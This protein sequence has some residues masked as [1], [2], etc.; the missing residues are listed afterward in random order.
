IAPGARLVVTWTVVNRGQA[1]AGRSAAAVLL[2]RDAKADARDVRLASVSS[3]SL[4][5]RK[6]A[7]ARRE[8]V[9]P[10]STTPGRY[11]VLV[12]ADTRRSVRESRETN[13]CRAAGT[14]EVER[15][16]TGVVVT[17]VPTQ[18]TPPGA[19]QSGAPPPG[20]P[21]PDPPPAV[22]SDTTPP[23]T[24]ITQAPGATTSSAAA[25]LVFQATEAGSSFQ[26]RLDDEAFAPCTSPKDYSGLLAGEHAFEVRATDAAGNRD[27]SPARAAW[28]IQFEAPAPG[29]TDQP[30]DAPETQAT[31]SPISDVSVL[32]DSTAFLYE[33]ADPI[34]KD[35]DDGAI[36]AERASVLR[37]RVTRRNGSPIGGVRVTALDHP[38]LGR[39]ATR[40]DGGFE[41]AVNG[42]GSIVVQ[43]EHE[44]YV[45]SQRTLEVPAQD[46]ERVDSIVLV[47]YDDQ[48]SGVDL[49]S[50][51]GELQVAESAPV[52]DGDG[53]RQATLLLEPGTDATATL[54]DGSTQSLP[55]VL[56]IRATE[57]TIGE[58]GP[59][60]MPGE[61]PPSSAYTYAVE[62]SVDE[63]SE[64]GAVSVEFDKPVVTYVDNYLE[65]PAG[66]IVPMGYYDREKGQWIA[67]PNGRVIAIVGKANGRAQLDV[68][69][70]GAADPPAEV[71]ALGID[72]AELAKLAELYPIGRSLW[73]AAISHFTPWDYNWPYGLPDGARP[74]GQPGPDDGDPDDDDRCGASGSI[75]LCES[76]TL[77]ESVRV[78][79]TPYELTY[80]SERQPGRRT[81][82]AL[83]IP[84]TG[85]TVPAN[86]ARVD[87]D[88]EVAGRTIS[89]SFPP[90]ANQAE[91]FIFDGKDAYQRTVQGRQRV[92]VR[93]DYVYPAVYREPGAFV[94]SFAAIGNAALSGNP[95]RTE[96]SVGQRWS[97]YVG[98]LSAP[99]GA[100]GGWGLDVHHSYDPIGRTLYLGDGTRRSA[101]GQNFDVISTLS[102][103]L[104]FP[105]GLAATEEGHLLV[106]DSSAHVIRRIAEDGTTTVVAGT[107]AAGYGGDG[108]PATAAVLNH[109]S[110]VAVTRD[111]S[112]LVA[113]E[114][115]N[116]V[117][118]IG[119]GGTISTVAGT[120]EGGYAGDGGPALGAALDE[121]SDVATA[122]DGA[123]Y[124]VDRANHAVRRIGPDG[125]I[126]TVAGNGTP[127]S[128]GD[129]GLGADARLR[130]PRD[131]TV[132]D[133][134][135]FV[136]DGGNHRVRRI[137]PGGT[138]HTVA[139]NGQDG[140]SGD[141]GRATDATLDTPSAIVALP[142]GG[143]LV[144]DA[145]SAVVRKVAPEGTIAT[146]AG[147]GTPG[148]RGDGSPAASARIDFPQALVLAPDG[149]VYLADAG[150]D[151]VRKLAP[152][153]P[154]LQ[155]GEFTLPDEDGQHLFVFSRSGRHLRTVDTLTGADVLRFLYDAQG[156]LGSV[157]D[158]D[159][160]ETT[161]N[162][163]PSQA[164]ASIVGPYGHTTSLQSS[165]AGLLG[166]IENPAGER[167]LMEYD[168]GGLLTKLT[169]E[170]DGVHTFEYDALGRLTKDVAPGNAVQTLSRSVQGGAVT[171]T[172]TSAEGRVTTYKMERTAEGAI[173]RTVTDPSGG[174][175]T[176]ERR[177]DGTTTATKPT[178]QVITRQVGPDPRFGMQA[179]VPE[180]TTVRTPA[181]RTRTSE[182]Q[183][184][185][186]LSDLADPLS[187]VKVVE[188]DTVNGRASTSTFEKD[189]HKLTTR[190]P[191]GAP[192]TMTFDEQRRPLTLKLSGIEP[193]E[194]SYDDDGRLTERR[195]ASRTWS[196]TYGSQ[197]LVTGQQ[198]PLGRT[199]TFTYDPVGRET[200]R[201][202]P[203]T[204][205]VQT[206]YS[207]MG[208]VTSLTPPG[209][210]AHTFSYDARRDVSS[211]APPTVGAAGAATFSYDRDHALLS[212][213]RADGSVLGLE[214]DAGGR[215]STVVDPDRSVTIGYA[216]VTHRP[217]S[218][219][220]P[221]E[222]VTYAYDA[223]LP[224]S[225]T[226]DGA[227]DGV[228]D[229]SYD[230]EFRLAEAS[231]NGGGAIGLGYDVDGHL[232]QVGAMSLSH[233]PDNKLLTGTAL[234][235]VTTTRDHNGFG[236]LV[237]ETYNA[238]SQIYAADLA[239]DAGGRLVSEMTSTEAGASTRTYAYDGAGR[240]ASATTDGQAVSYSYDANGN[241]LSTTGPAGTTTAD[242]D[243]QD[244]LTRW[245]AQ[246]YAYT[247]SGELRTATDGVTGD[248]TTYEWDR[249]GTLMRVDLPGVA[250]RE[251]TVDGQG[252]RVAVSDNGSIVAR[253]VYGEAAGPSA[254]LNADGTVRTRYAY[255]LRGHVPELMVRGGET[256][257]FVLD[258]RGSVRLVVNT[259][260]GEVA[261]AMTYD[262]FGNVLTDSN[263]GFQPFGF[264]GGLYDRE[265]K[266]VHFGARD[267]DPATGRW[268]SKDPILFSGGDT[269]LYAYVFQDPVNLVDPSGLIFD[270][271]LDVAFIAYDL[272][273]IGESL[274]NGCGVSSTDAAAL[275]ADILGA[276]IPFGTGGGAA[277]R[278]ASKA[279]G[280]VNV[281]S[282]QR[283]THILHGDK[284]GGGHLW[285]GRSGKTPFPQSWSADRVMHEVSD[286]A[287]DPASRVVSTNGSRTVVEGTRDGVVI[288]VVTD[289]R[290]IITGHP[291]NLPRNP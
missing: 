223:S 247:A 3:R 7:K 72:D 200:S 12:C 92:D 275:G 266:L 183:R 242:Y 181:G 10:A 83:E 288:R 159:G 38:E 56:N 208:E 220:T 261:Q 194:W 68:D 233:D 217:E 173:K 269:N 224:V 276:A 123:L 192:S 193:V 279:D 263:P 31:P 20:A 60:A 229:L 85:A 16:P 108:G 36:E 283:T 18:G 167:V 70:D 69:G 90:A 63:A 142:D 236:E 281:A 225:A 160:L 268:I 239:R 277:V 139:G 191:S 45:T 93:I 228:V 8:V 114:G 221:D 246:T 58:S 226:F 112:V 106:A 34:Q 265:T 195:Q 127:G 47:P 174:V 52:T 197:G 201:V 271:I 53:T 100:L 124:V 179:P 81:S 79:G 267:Y 243:A 46:F 198:D 66:T 148:F 131:V 64:D 168:A 287:T 140:Y 115:N 23:D 176:S 104:S 227:S 44:G 291:V 177:I 274:L 37:G 117:R 189:G 290:D 132:R 130:S 71:G 39:T 51:S 172:R 244:R 67:A 54:P 48:V 214:Y 134:S 163:N 136:A 240:L 59:S 133:G 218:I 206:A 249:Q 76:Q 146:I 82:D 101:E 253:Y 57:Y 138:I 75:I 205:T 113:D 77:G 6:S 25:H 187:V 256:Y 5:Q 252:R 30:A 238:G 42:G 15:G 209:R 258:V 284:T 65:F 182:V 204:R 135:V 35:V 216:G 28:R 96:I 165:A 154:G 186:E 211:Y 143:L 251:Y 50:G 273:K 26:C 21:P 14:V 128:G 111:G 141:G 49:S 180:R 185:V 109:P 78:A 105:E 262:E 32:S 235:S 116:R 270:T 213:Q 110:D 157:R 199:T 22:G 9:V 170:V 257:R 73:R 169:D 13:N 259:S 40:P 88:I 241:R 234:G 178:G 4:K 62:Y 126:T 144:A 119:P 74:P 166:R 162:R 102:D 147:N 121:P 99:A 118:R 156:R 237:S 232:S 190:L 196:W 255:G 212:T 97:G 33:T 230:D 84:L 264:A 11:R 19:T 107:G 61:L 80:T 164:P 231:V 188:T 125:I 137:D 41:L 155:L 207:D 89:K 122:A 153:L 245:G 87:L 260:T 91:T 120:G 203:G 280:F 285:P 219:A 145:G 2:S 29:P 55:D 94:S 27:E 150:N 98:G 175:S 289:G 103:G 171:V 254:D 17:P 222:T 1:T 158:G 161:I 278:A 149:T 152:G 86:L 250:S 272:Y 24:T 282:K 215:V 210:P 129:E 43:F 286:V 184:Q 95:A 248:V 202:L 151:R